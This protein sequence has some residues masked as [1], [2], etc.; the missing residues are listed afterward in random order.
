MSFFAKKAF[1]IFKKIY[2]CVRMGGGTAK[3]SNEI[4]ILYI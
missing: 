3:L 2:I 4:N 1:N